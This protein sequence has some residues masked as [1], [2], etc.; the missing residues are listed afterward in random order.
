MSNQEQEL[1]EAVT[2]SEDPE[3]KTSDET[4]SS[5]GSEKIEKSVEKEE[6]NSSSPSE[7][8]IS[9]DSDI[10]NKQETTRR[11][12]I[13]QDIR[14]A[15]EQGDREKLMAKY[16]NYQVSDT[17]SCNVRFLTDHRQKKN[18]LGRNEGTDLKKSFLPILF[19]TEEISNLHSIGKT[20]NV[21]MLVS[22]YI[23]FLINILLFFHSRLIKILQNIHSKFLVQK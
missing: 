13:P 3:I 16:N 7:K 17:N 20:F 19:F 14:Y 4:Q 6:S 15:T 2:V 1:S 11:S 18:L 12:T 8:K 10:S 21:N 22:V 5:N 9:N 23:L